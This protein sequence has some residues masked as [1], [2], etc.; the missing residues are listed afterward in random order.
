MFATVYIYTFVDEVQ[1]NSILLFR[2]DQKTRH[3]G[4]DD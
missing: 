1:L 2:A 4:G 3:A